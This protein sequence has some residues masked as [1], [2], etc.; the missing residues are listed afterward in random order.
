MADEKISRLSPEMQAYVRTPEFKAW[1]GDWENDPGHSS[2]VVDENGEPLLVWHGSNKSFDR[3]DLSMGGRNTGGGEWTDSKRPGEVVADDATKAVFFTPTKDAAI[4][5]SMLAQ[6]HENERKRRMFES[7]LP[8][9]QSLT[10]FG[11]FKTREELLAALEEA[12]E[13]VPEIRPVVDA[14]HTDPG[15]KIISGIVASLPAVKRAAITEGLIAVRGYYRQRTEAMSRGGLAN[16]RHNMTRQKAEVASLKGNMDRL[17]RN[18]R[19]VPNEFGTFEDY[20]ATL[21]GSGYDSLTLTFDDDG[22][23]MF[24][25]EGRHIHLDEA[26]DETIRWI[27]DTM[28][29]YTADAVTQC[30]KEIRDNGFQDDANLY[31]CFLNI[32]NPLEHDYEGSAMPDK[33]KD[34]RYTS[35][36]VAARQVRKATEDGNDGVVYRRV[37]D[38]FEMDSFGVFGEGQIQVVAV[39]KTLTQ[40]PLARAPHR[41]DAP[42][43]TAEY[44]HPVLEA[45]LREAY[46]GQYLVLEDT[47][48][49]GNPMEGVKVVRAIGEDGSYAVPA[50][51]LHTGTD[52]YAQGS[53]LFCNT[54]AAILQQADGEV[55]LYS[56]AGVV[57]SVPQTAGEYVEQVMRTSRLDP[58]GDGEADVYSTKERRAG[59][60]FFTDDSIPWLM[61]AAAALEAGR[62]IVLEDG[63]RASVPDSLRMRFDSEYE[64]GFWGGIDEASETVMLRHIFADMPED[65]QKELLAG[66]IGPNLEDKEKFPLPGTSLPPMDTPERRLR[67]FELIPFNER[68]VLVGRWPAEAVGLGQEERRD[69]RGKQIEIVAHKG[70]W[71]REEAVADPENIYIFTDNTDRDSGR[72]LVPRSSRYYVTYGDGD[73]DLH[74]PTQT[75]AV[76]RGLPN[77]LPVSTQRWYHD[78][79]KGTSGR[80]QDAD[81]EEFRSV[82]SSEFLD[83]RREIL[84]RAGHVGKVFIPDGNGFFG[85]KISQITRERVPALYHA[86]NEE[87]YGLERFVGHLNEVLDRAA[88]ME[89]VP[90]LPESIPSSFPGYRRELRLVA[91]RFL[92]GLDTV[93]EEDGVDYSFADFYRAY[94]SGIRMEA[95]TM[96]LNELQALA[97]R[98]YEAGDLSEGL[99]AEAETESIKM[100]TDMPNNEISQNPA[101]W[102]AG[103]SLQ[104]KERAFSFFYREDTGPGPFSAEEL[105]RMK[106][107][108]DLVRNDPDITAEEGA[109]YLTAVFNDLTP[110]Q[111]RVMMQEVSASMEYIEEETPAVAEEHSR[112]AAVPEEA[113]NAWLDT[114]STFSLTSLLRRYEFPD[115]GVSSAFDAAFD[116]VNRAT[117]PGWTQGLDEAA[118][119]ERALAVFSG[120]EPEVKQ[121]FYEAGQRMNLAM[122]TSEEQDY[123]VYTLGTSTRSLDEFLQLIPAGVT[124]VVDVRNYPY[125]KYQPHFNKSV[126]TGELRQRGI[127]YES[128]KA[129]SGKM[130]DAL[131]TGK[132]D[133]YDY[134]KVANTDAYKEA[135]AK[136]RRDVEGPGKVLIIS[137]EG[138]PAK[139]QRAMLIGQSL[140][141]DGINAGHIATDRHGGVHIYS[142]DSVVRSLMGRSRIVDGTSGRIYF[143]SDGHW[144]PGEGVQVVKT[145]DDVENRLIQGNWNYGRSVEV[146]END[147]PGFDASYQKLSRQADFTVC[148]TTRH[149]FSH[150]KRVVKFAGIDG[151]QITIPD[152]PVQM[153]DPET[154]RRIVDR[155]SARLTKSLVYHHGLD[156]GSVDVNSVKLHIGGADRAR[157]TVKPIETKVTEEE[158]AGTRQEMFRKTGG[159]AAGFK[160]DDQTGVTQE[161]ANTLMRNVLKELTERSMSMDFEDASGAYHTPFRISEILTNGQTGI[162]E[163]TVV[164]SQALGLNVSVLAPKGFLHTLDDETLAGREVSD[165]AM[166]LNRFHLGERNAITMDEVREQVELSARAQR[167]READLTPGLTDRQILLLSRLGFENSDILKMINLADDNGVVLSYTR[168]TAADGTAFNSC[169]RDLVEFVDLC[170]GYGVEGPEHF[171]EEIVAAAEADLDKAVQKD[172]EEGIGYITVNSPEYPALLRSY[173]GFKR[174][175]EENILTHNAETGVA[176]MES[177]TKEVTEEMPAILR[178]KGDPRAL[179]AP[180]V[181]VLGNDRR[182]SE[183]VSRVAKLIGARLK[184]E[185]VAVVSVLRDP[186]I[187]AHSTRIEGFVEGYVDADV[188]ARREHPGTPNKVMARADSQSA[189]FNEAVRG[190]G[191]AVVFSPRGLSRPEDAD[192]TDRIAQN[193]GIVLTEVMPWTDGDTNGE[194]VNRELLKDSLAERAQRFAAVTGGVSLVLDGMSERIQGSPLAAAR[195]AAYGHYAVNYPGLEGIY[196]RQASNEEAR[197]A[198]FSMVETSLAGVDALVQDALARSKDTIAEA[199]Q[200]E[201]AESAAVSRDEPLHPDRYPFSVIRRGTDQVF[202]VPERYPDVRE[203]VRKAYGEDVVFAENARETMKE[204]RLRRAVV[205]GTEVVLF[206]GYRGTQV[207]EAPV[208]SVPLFYHAGSIYSMNTAPDDTPGLASQR[209]RTEQRSL[210]EQFKAKAVE[211]QGK[212]QEAAGFPGSD[213]I[214]F[215]NALHPVITPDAVSIY[216]G[217]TLR[218]R[219]F[220]SQNGTIRVHNET[221]LVDDLQEHVQ[222]RDPFFQSAGG[223]IDKVG[224][225][226][227]AIMMEMRLMGTSVAETDMYAVA[228]R[229]QREEIRE[230]I[231]Q[232]WEKPSAD[233]VDVASTD[234]NHGESAGLLAKPG[235]KEADCEEVFKALMKE[236]A[237]VRKAM[238][239]VEK[240]ES[241]LQKQITDVTAARDE[242]HLNAQSSEAYKAFDQQILEL[243]TE[244]LTVQEKITSQKAEIAALA[245]LMRRTATMDRITVSEEGEKADVVSLA[246]RAVT[247]QKGTFTKAI[248]EDFGPMMDGY[249]ADAAARKEAFDL[250]SRREASTF[251]ADAIARAFDSGRKAPAKE[252]VEKPKEGY[253]LKSEIKPGTQLSNGKYIIVRNGREAYADENLK[254]V[255]KFYE[256]LYDFKKHYGCASNGGK[257]NYILPDGSEMLSVWIDRIAKAG[258]GH[259]IVCTDGMYNHINGR[260]KLLSE[261]WCENCRAFFD[262]WAII[263]GGPGDGPNQG[264]F[265]YINPKGNILF[266]D[267][268]ED[269]ADFKDGIG[270]I[271][272]GG[273][274]LPIDTKGN[275]GK[276]LQNYNWNHSHTGRNKGV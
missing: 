176:A 229:E 195:D 71:T 198:G 34:T 139:S 151:V 178:F 272:R 181:A 87:T 177:V 159:A 241:K 164:A 124:K 133:V 108:V 240:Q 214:H 173:G 235:E 160:L 39:E 254:I 95:A 205:D 157:L 127:S 276:P 53:E 45:A 20:N 55:S 88:A 206:D 122:R 234:I 49:N 78:G 217:D 175:V 165:K 163:A 82:I 183:E 154:A 269:A 24:H 96:T 161:D 218:A 89:T 169:A 238:K 228:D 54:A 62:E 115:E 83:I 222:R 106:D 237:K 219:V 252:T 249:R 112:A 144:T 63:A 185:G 135:Y 182:S 128:A 52:I 94:P 233:N 142:Q 61:E 267:W 91:A 116:A 25:G 40:S 66:W 15:K 37:R 184:D 212:F 158:L 79:A 58:Y 57:D 210:F 145:Q 275:I 270:V 132:R 6:H 9:F 35:A 74:Y 188:A 268:A 186:E 203:A 51:R 259:W 81:V 236:T 50:E 48:E 193:G 207:Q 190:G 200:E 121:S 179:S 86:L 1:F 75:T 30:N 150:D 84:S 33:Y 264:K 256:R 118:I 114:L 231:E 146:R 140:Q 239:A 196:E 109:A 102:F 220:I 232:G 156:P 189:A 65:R 148:L 110:D 90:R 3:F 26:D 22:R 92:C 258:E 31:A 47:D 120:F 167:L 202:V 192:E 77:A 174:T 253:A 123:D 204:M 4:S 221:R 274:D 255:S 93:W 141:R 85:G 68:G 126:L 125:N 42:V 117:G 266:A 262:G 199:V 134:V 201:A 225:D 271:R 257:F 170:G 73:R 260:G 137:S 18:D 60:S 99:A 247:I 13:A 242:A 97:A 23:C 215:E 105:R 11:D 209:V 245:D 216:E 69:I 5:Y 41:V 248:E 103:L 250:S 187:I 70:P 191:I 113:I 136:L 131:V 28:D 166:F 152:D 172:R 100:E 197:K 27:K 56:V 223:F 143:E 67:L 101:E 211:I 21:F 243:E 230:K 149:S 155:I 194:F 226:S 130:E 244:L 168:E 180:S 14:A 32:R 171:S 162:S 29:R 251:E 76:L 64:P 138:D 80:W 246:G 59:H 2:K 265:N 46:R 263:Q 38:P 261:D 111:R 8:V 19:T 12:S 119:R 273:K 16:F 227:L 10:H 104:D 224:V 36:Y 129:L 43:L 7:L 44:R 208:Y 72:G 98:I 147:V 107:M 153:R 17:R 213:P